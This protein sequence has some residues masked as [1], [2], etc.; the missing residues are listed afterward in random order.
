MLS[1]GPVLHH[2]FPPGDGKVLLARHEGV[3]D[4]HRMLALPPGIE[5]FSDPTSDRMGYGDV[6]G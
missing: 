5:P 1:L 3:A 2:I 4:K 6:T